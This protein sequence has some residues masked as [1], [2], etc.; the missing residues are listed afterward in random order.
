MTAGC[1]EP[2]LPPDGI[3]VGGQMVVDGF[4]NATTKSVRVKL[5]RALTLADANQSPAESNASVKIES[6][7]GTVYTLTE[8]SDTSRPGIYTASNLVLDAGAEYTLK[9]V[10][11]SGRSYS[12]DPVKLRQPPAMDS[13]VWR[14]SKEGIQPA[15]ITFYVNTHDSEKN[16]RY[17]RW[18][19]IESWE[20]TMQF[21]SFFKK[22][23]SNRP[24]V[25]DSGEHVFR[26]Y[27]SLPSTNIMVESTTRLSDDRVTM[28][29]IHFIRRG[30]RKLQRKTRLI[31][32][33]YAITQSEFEFWQ[34]MRKTTETLG[35]L[36][37]P[38]PSQVLGNVHSDDNS[39]ENVLGFFSG[40]FVT[41]KRI[42]VGLRDL[43]G[44]LS[45]VDPITSLCNARQVPLASIP[46][47][48]GINEEYV[49]TYGF[50]YIE[51]YLVAPA[52]C[53]DCTNLGGT[54]STP[55]DWPTL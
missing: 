20:Y 32:Q 42:Y 10:T 29:P 25:R 22:D 7:K 53:V 39:S 16:T 34:L 46:Q 45:A 15:G 38:M 51:G 23:G 49:T 54:N 37:D 17:Y 12:S 31:V 48:V 50:P 35:G 52:Q 40:G 2:Y 26:C 47:D 21:Y 55:P 11:E 33:Q 43:P 4:L 13:I 41:E 28:F 44:Y 8:T 9:I 30:D 1:V 14:P 36:F 5:S 18:S 19:F 3:G 6:N 27:G 24:V